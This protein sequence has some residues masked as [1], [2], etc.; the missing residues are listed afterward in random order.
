MAFAMKH[1]SN[2]EI[3]Q[4]AGQRTAIADRISILLQFHSRKCAVTEE[5]RVCRIEFDGMGVEIRSFRKVMACSD[6]SQHD[7]K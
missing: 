3:K 4:Q 7:G 6:S 1:L 5:R 2:S